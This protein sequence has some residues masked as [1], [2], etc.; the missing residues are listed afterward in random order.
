MGVVYRDDS[1]YPLDQGYILE[2]VPIRIPEPNGKHRET[3]M[4]AVV[5]QHG[6]DCEKFDHAKEKNQATDH[7]AVQVAPVF[8]IKHLR[9][10]GKHKDIRSGR[11]PQYFSIPSEDKRPELVADLWLEQPLP[12]ADLLQ[13]KRVDSL[14]EEWCRRLVIQ[15]F[16]LRSRVEVKDVFRE[17]FLSDET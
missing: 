3:H 1:E 16:V 12:T 15:I 6:C 4:L 17:E 8:E 9:D 13:L 2:R 14:S 10:D 11:V 5:T 7:F